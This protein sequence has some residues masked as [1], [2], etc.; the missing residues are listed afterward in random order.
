MTHYEL[1]DG[2]NLSNIIDIM[3]SLTERTQQLTPLTTRGKPWR[4]RVWAG[5]KIVRPH[6]WGPWVMKRFLGYWVPKTAKSST[7]H[8]RA[9]QRNTY[10]LKKNKEKKPEGKR[11]FPEKSRT[12]WQSFACGS[13]LTWQW[14]WWPRNIAEPQGFFWPGY[15]RVY[16]PL[17]VCHVNKTIHMFMVIAI[18]TELPG[19]GAGSW[20]TKYGGWDKNTMSWA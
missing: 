13:Y 17:G 11:P 19:R 8:N 3:N 1:N 15:W 18:M 7:S 5:P 6:R 10:V 20:Y 4:L 2:T 9:K 16:T 14:A 12:H